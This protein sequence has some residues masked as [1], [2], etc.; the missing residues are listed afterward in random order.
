MSKKTKKGTKLDLSDMRVNLQDSLPKGPAER[1]E[2]DEGR[3]RRNNREYGESWVSSAPN[4]VGPLRMLRAFSH[5]REHQIWRQHPS[6]S[7]TR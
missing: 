3:F 6:R 2:N 1:D 7:S 4:P 5:P